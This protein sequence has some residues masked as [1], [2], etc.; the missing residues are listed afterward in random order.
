MLIS[1]FAEEPTAPGA[2]QAPLE[3]FAMNFSRIEYSYRPQKAD[4]TLDTPW[5]DHLRP[6]D[7]EGG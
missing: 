4:G 3:E 6:Q 7:R 5:H 2:P 1:K